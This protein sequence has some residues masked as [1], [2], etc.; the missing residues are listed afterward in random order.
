[1]QTDCEAEQLTLFGPD[2]WKGY[3]KVD[4]KSKELLQ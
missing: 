3:N 2:L 1:M 4:R